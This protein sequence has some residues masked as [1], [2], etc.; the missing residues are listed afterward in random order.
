MMLTLKK[1]L[2]I[3]RHGRK[4]RK[5]PKMYL[6]PKKLR[7]KKLLN[8]LILIMLK[9]KTRP[10]KIQQEKNRKQIKYPP[11]KVKL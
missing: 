4:Q 1:K 5:Y 8:K 7:S 6:K 2:L 3:I 11:R 9:L 10:L